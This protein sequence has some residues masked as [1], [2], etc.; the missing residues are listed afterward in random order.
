MLHSELTVVTMSTSTYLEPGPEH[1][2]GAPRERLVSG[3]LAWVLLSS[4]AA[5]TS[6]ELM[7]SVTPMYA[8]AAGAGSAGAGLATGMLL[9]GTVAAELAATPLMRRYRHRTLL[10]AGAARLRGSGPAG[11]HPPMLSCGVQSQPGRILIGTDDLATEDRLI[12]RGQGRRFAAIND[13][14][15]HAG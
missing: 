10:V 11:S 5:M 4:C 15:R 3:P 13:H 14:G 2:V 7:L 12:E 9:L 1:S 6:F 8:A